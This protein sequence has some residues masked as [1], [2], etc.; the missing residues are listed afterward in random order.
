MSGIVFDVRTNIDEMAKNMGMLEKDIPFMAAYALTKTAQDIQAA[1]VAEMQSVFDRPTRFTLNSLYVKPATK[2]DLSAAVFPKAGFG[3]IPAWRFLGPQIQGGPRQ[4][5]AHERALERAG[6]LQANEY[7]VPG[8]G[9][10]L[11]AHG[12]IPGPTIVRILS[13]VGAAE[14]GVGYLANMTGRSRKRAV[15]RAGGQFFVM[16]ERGVPPGIYQRVSQGSPMK[17][18]V[19]PTRN[20]VLPI[21]LFV[22]A[23][24][25]QQ[26]FRFYDIA[27]EK[28]AENFDRHFRVAWVRYAKPTR[29][30]A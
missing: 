10:K 16:R 29:M 1:E 28:F 21:L 8:A 20:R 19:G 5:K 2:E 18:G 15:R 23:P 30:A 24:N 22:S 6:I 3:S 14:R 7:A 12:N 13:Q 25:Y 27:N 26:R 17:G 9:V 11:D 4:K